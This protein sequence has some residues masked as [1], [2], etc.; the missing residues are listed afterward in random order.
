M[1]ITY[2]ACLVVAIV[3]LSTG[4]AR[5]QVPWPDLGTEQLPPDPTVP[6]L[7]AVPPLI[8]LDGDGAC[9]TDLEAQLQTRPDALGCG[10]DAI[11][12]DASLPIPQAIH[13]A[14][15]TP[16]FF[17]RPDRVNHEAR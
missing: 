9:L 16:G 8:C 1:R 11:C 2:A 3:A 13:D 15:G 10:H 14:T 4:S 12:S 7:P 17:E 6:Y 5:A